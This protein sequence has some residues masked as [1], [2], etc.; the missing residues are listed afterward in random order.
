MPSI[1]LL[2]R[3]QKSLE[4]DQVRA[5]RYWFHW[6]HTA[7]PWTRGGHRLGWLGSLTAGDALLQHGSPVWL[8]TLST[9]SGF[10]HGVK[11]NYLE[12]V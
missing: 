5:Q 8:P 2:R 9:Y 10:V 12:L 11:P 7:A 1:V 4:P 6:L 3:R